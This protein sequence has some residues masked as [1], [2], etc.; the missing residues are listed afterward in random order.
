M[1][2]FSMS[3]ICV[4]I[5]IAKLTFVAAIRVNNKDKVKSFSNNECGFK[6]FIDW[7]QLFLDENCHCCMEST[8]KYGNALA[9][10]L[11]TNNHVVS[12]V[13][14]AKIKYFMKSQ[15]ARSK[16]DFV[17]A[18]LICSYCEIFKPSQWQPLPTETQELQALVKRLDTLNNMVLQEQ[19]RLENVAS[20]IENSINNNILYLKNEI[21]SIEKMIVKHVDGNLALKKDSDLLKSIPGIGE[22][23]TNKTLAF[24][25]HIK[26]FEKAKQVAA[27][28]GI[29]PQHAQ[30]GTSLNHSHI[31]KTGDAELRKMLYMPALVAIQCEPSIKTFY[32]KLV[33]KG[34]P[35]K[36][37]ICAVMRKLI[38]IIYGVLKSQKPFNAK[39]ICAV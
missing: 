36:V 19:N 8:G 29:N 38:H 2:K 22:K 10:F 4:G 18:K 9:L 35:K 27:F 15:L 5:D 24:L 34:K 20:I 1:R 16:T 30:S 31:S 28:I 6:K 37:A 7:L 17:D 33:A 39:L 26:D 14:P 21:K 13:N 23:T 12:I 11:H 25:C 3:K 32:E